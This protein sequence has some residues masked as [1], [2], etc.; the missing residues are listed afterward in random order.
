MDYSVLEQEFLAIIHSLLDE[1]FC[2]PIGKLYF[3]DFIDSNGNRSSTNCSI[4]FIM[5]PLP[6]LMLV[7]IV[8][9]IS[10]RLA[11]YAEWICFYD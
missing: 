9:K 6:K 11:K 7:I 10:I 4:R 3:D 1:I 5:S 2:S 8:Q